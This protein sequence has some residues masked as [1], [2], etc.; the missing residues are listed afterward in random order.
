MKCILR[1]ATCELQR[2]ITVSTSRSEISTI[3]RKNILSALTL[4]CYR[5]LYHSNIDNHID[6]TLHPSIKHGPEVFVQRK[7]QEDAASGR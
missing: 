5:I 2:S 1:R 3:T 6:L 7:C 4:I